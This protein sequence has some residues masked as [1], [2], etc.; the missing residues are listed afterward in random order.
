MI[1]APH[2]LFA[3][4]PD[5]NEDTQL[6]SSLWELINI[7]RPGTAMLL[8]LC[9]PVCHTLSLSCVHILKCEP[10][11]AGCFHFLPPH[12]F[13]FFLIKGIRPPLSFS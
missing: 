11:N 13:V 12:S 8:P 1:V 10:Q 5:R 4:K 2:S 3:G 7:H 6:S 9:V